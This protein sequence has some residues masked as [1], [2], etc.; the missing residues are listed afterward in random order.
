M[1]RF[2]WKVETAFSSDVQ[3]T[4]T[5]LASWFFSSRAATATQV[6]E[7]G[8]HLVAVDSAGMIYLARGAELWRLTR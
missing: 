8:G 6:A 3:A 7:T 4:L 5:S 1:S 2:Q